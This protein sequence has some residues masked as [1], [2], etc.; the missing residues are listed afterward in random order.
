MQTPSIILRLE[1][2]LGEKSVLNCTE[3]ALLLY[4]KSQK[5]FFLMYLKMI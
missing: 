4:L 2:P 3:C 1:Q 5:Y